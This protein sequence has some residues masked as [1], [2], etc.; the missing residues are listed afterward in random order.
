M[1]LTS[2]RAMLLEILHLQQAEE[3]TTLET[4]HILSKVTQTS[5]C[6]AKIR[7]EVTGCCR[8]GLDT[9]E[10]HTHTHTHSHV[11]THVLIER[12]RWEAAITRRSHGRQ[13]SGK[14]EESQEVKDPTEGEYCP[15]RRARD[16]S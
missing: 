12:E 7:M 16:P 4:V 10:S 13:Q 3:L 9:I 15:K 2:F 11:Y 8:L 14:G 6:Q 5:E 1:G